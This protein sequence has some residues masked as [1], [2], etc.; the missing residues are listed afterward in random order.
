M[1]NIN[2]AIH[3]L[4]AVAGVILG[5]LGIIATSCYAKKELNII[6]AEEEVEHLLSS[7]FQQIAMLRDF[8]IDQAKKVS[9]AA[10][11]AME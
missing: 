8:P 10:Q 4:L 5:V 7:K 6:T 1:N 11:V 9:L 2:L 3:H